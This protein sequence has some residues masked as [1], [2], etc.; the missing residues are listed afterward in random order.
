MVI[1]MG[2]T[3]IEERGRVLIPKEV[4]EKLGLRGGEKIRVE[5]E[6]GNVIIRPLKDSG[7]LEQLK[8]CVKE[9]EIEPLELKKMWEM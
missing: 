9:S 7:E 4:R 2:I 5:E 3:S 6:N 8:G 1:E